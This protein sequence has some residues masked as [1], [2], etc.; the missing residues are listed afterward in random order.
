M[1]Q[2]RVAKKFERWVAKLERMGSLKMRDVWLCEREGVVKS[3]REMGGYVRE[4]GWLKK[5][6]MGG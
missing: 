4:M 3:E 2:N 6:E 1:R 5:L